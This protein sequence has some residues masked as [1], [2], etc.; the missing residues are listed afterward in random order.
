VNLK[1]LR[2]AAESIA[3]SAIRAVD[4]EVLIRKSVNL[5][6]DTLTV[7]ECCVDLSEFKRIFAVGGG[8]AGGSMAKA[9]EEILG[10]RL[11]GGVIV[12]KD[13]YARPLKRLTLLEAG[14]PVPDER[15]VEASRRMLAL[16]AEHAR[17]DTLV[18][19]L[20]SGGG[21]ALMPLPADGISLSDKQQTTR[22]L[23]E[24]GASIDEI[25]TVRK[26]ISRIKGGQLARAAAPAR[27]ISLILSDVVGD[28]LDVIASGA[29]IGDSS[30]YSD[31]ETVLRNYKIWNRV[32]K[33]VCETIKYGI[34]GRIK[35]T[36]KPGEEIFENVSNIIIGNNQSAVEAASAEAA[37]LGFHSLIL[38][39]CLVGEAREVGTVLASI[40]I[41]VAKRGRPVSAPACIL[42][43]GETTVT[44]RGGGMGGRNQELALAAA[45]RISN[46]ERNMVIAS[47]GTDGTDGP[48]D[49][50]GAIVDTT[51]VA[52][53]RGQGLDP[54]QY[55]VRND[56]YNALKPI[57]DL[58]VTGPT[59]TNVM[60]I[61]MALIG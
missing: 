58:L 13:G 42:A 56:S 19:C 51:T 1:E 49:A 23:L 7:G 40:A 31:A 44:I 12:V 24:C 27:L 33:I 8:K 57:G 38:S 41:E 9:L 47:V 46:A 28:S 43:G 21:S 35:E 5:A 52:R 3:R 14:H 18:L 34:E 26:H 15:G 30:T 61:L 50:A 60:D 37:S 54:L 10:D 32:P 48:T 36:P 2:E 6:G 45:L 4:P 22:L 53:A 20:I 55:L 25:N 59:G 39:T 11:S 29:T 17:P 16:L